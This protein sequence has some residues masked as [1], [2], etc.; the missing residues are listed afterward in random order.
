[1]EKN[2]NPLY[3]FC[4]AR[5]ESVPELQ[6][7]GV[8]GQRPVFVLRAF[9]GLCAVVSETALED[10]CGPTA[11]QRMEQLAWISP[12]ALRHE[13]VVEEV[14]RHSPVLPARFGTLFSSREKLTEFLAQQH[15]AIARFLERIADQDEWSLKG[16]LNRRQAVQSLTSER[17]AAAQAQL[18]R[19]SPGR[20]Y[21]EEKR[22][23]A[24]AEKELQRWVNQTCNDLAS[25]LREQA[26]DF[27]DCGARQS[28][29]SP[30]D[31]S[32]MVMNW[33]FLLGKSAAARF[34][35]RIDR[36]NSRPPAPV[37]AFELSGP[38]P[39][40]RFVPPLLTGAPP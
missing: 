16:F 25:E 20:R 37:L 22:V 7:T 14:M 40:Y 13:S 30:E 17:L 4:F 28:A 6:V 18:A 35:S 24:E 26:A 12:R 33:A 31:E 11:E 32:E 29:S 27:Y 10:F 9:P 2:A 39:P 8:D 38:W 1:M 15:Q 23:R 5:S 36:L 34:R 21:F 19:L 3:L